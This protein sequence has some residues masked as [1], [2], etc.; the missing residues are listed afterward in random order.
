MHKKYKCEEEFL[1]L[2]HGKTFYMVM[3]EEVRR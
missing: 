1:I 3:G 2:L